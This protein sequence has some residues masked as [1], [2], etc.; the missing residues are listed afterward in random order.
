VRALVLTGEEPAW[1]LAERPDPDCGPADVLVD[2]RAAGLNRGDLFLRTG[3]YVPT[4]ENW[5]VPH[6]RVGYDL[7]GVVRAIG[8]EVT[9][10]RVGQAVLAM[11]GGACADLVT[12]D[13]RLLLAMPDGLDW[14]RAAAL[15]SALMTEYDA[16]AVRGRLQDG[17]V[18]LVLGGSTG[19]GL[20]G[21]QLARALGAARV[22]ATTRDPGKAP[23]LRELGADRVIDTSTES[24]AE[25]VREASGGHGFDL[26]LDHLGGEVLAQ[27]LPSAASR[28]RI[29][30][31]GRLAG[32]AS[33]VDLDILASRRIELI[34][35]TF[36]GRRLSEL[37]ELTAGLRAE[38]LP[39]VAAGAVRPVIEAEFPAARAEDAATYLRTR[40]TTGKLVVTGFGTG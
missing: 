14:V 6:D 19:I 35:T 11:A 36:R 31:I 10:F 39:L 29:V 15:P 1:E 13:H 4:G 37:E 7:A 9:D 16:L 34:G 24:V 30:Q 3:K 25:V 38:V 20:V 23:V 12:V 2:V 8:A 26:A 17:E 5:Q 28:A 21:I 32:R 33:T 27:S 40:S 18:V 22:L